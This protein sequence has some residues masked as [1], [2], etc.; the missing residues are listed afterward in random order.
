MLRLLVLI[1]ICIRTPRVFYEGDYIRNLESELARAAKLKCS[2]C[3][4]KGAGLGCFAKSCRR[5]YHAP[6]AFGIQ[7][8]RW[9]CVCKLC[10]ASI[11][12]KL[13]SFLYSFRLFI[14]YCNKIQEDFLMLCPSH[15]SLKFPRERSKFR[16]SATMKHPLS[17][18]S[19]QMYNLLFCLIHYFKS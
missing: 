14:T 16:K 4:L 19:T 3:G 11:L 8:C 18:D 12:S 9:D 1:K 15:N 17:A 6:C 13:N 5:T 2:L 10:H 7:E